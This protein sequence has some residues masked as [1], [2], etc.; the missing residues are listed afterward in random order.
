MSKITCPY[1]ERKFDVEQVEEAGL[2]V[3]RGMLQ[4]RL[5]AGWQIACEYTDCFRQRAGA[6]VTLKK[7]ARIL[8]EVAKLWETCELEYDGKRYRTDRRAIR[9]GLATVCNADKVGFGNHNY[10]KRVLINAG[11]QRVS[12]EG[13]TAEEE[14]RSEEQKRQRTDP[15]SPEGYAAASDGEG[16]SAEEYKRR[17]G[18]ES[19]AD[20][21]GKDLNDPTCEECGDPLT[22]AEKQLEIKHKDK[23]CSTCR[24]Y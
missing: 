17:H 7:R 3:E 16:M 18:I 19:L 20:S 21:V 13:K 5:G 9:E 23:L 24:R 10:L 4:E 22:E 2:W 1:C 11:A 8:G 15:A 14:R 12:A 6:R